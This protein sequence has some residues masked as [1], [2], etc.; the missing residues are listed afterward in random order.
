MS[1]APGT[2]R[3]KIMASVRRALLV[4]GDEPGR[5]GLVRAR[6][7]RTPSGIIPE[8]AQKPKPELIA[9]FKAM[10]EVQGTGVYELAHI[11]ELPAALAALLAALNLPA[12]LRH[13]ADPLW[14]DLPWEDTLIEREEGPAQPEDLVSLS[15]AMAGAAETGTVFLT[16]GADNPSTLNFLPETHC[17]VIMADAIYGSFEEIWRLIRQIHGKGNLP[18]TVNLVSGPSCTADIEQTIIRG[19]HGP[20]RLGVFIVGGA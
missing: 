4:R 13:G 10:L 15:R 14:H 3:D 5:R 18:R 6:L 12:K 20:R 17:V 19:A 8:R 7:E 16:S 1:T 11:N 2:G 9:G